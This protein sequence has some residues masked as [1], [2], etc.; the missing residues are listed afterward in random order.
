MRRA[1][2]AKSVDEVREVYD[3]GAHEYEEWNVRSGYSIPGQIVAAS[4]RFVARDAL[5]LDAGAGSG[6]AG[7]LLAQA[8][9]AHID[10]TD[11]SSGML[12]EAHRK[13]VYRDLRLNTLGERLD[14]D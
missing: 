7:V 1:Y 2:A 5:L 11:I 9:Y 10:G 8:G 3:T 6:L 14:Y 12:A 13:G 4:E